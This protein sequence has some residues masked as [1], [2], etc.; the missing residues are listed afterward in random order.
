[1]KDREKKY[2]EYIDGKIDKY[3]RDS[4]SDPKTLDLSKMPP[5]TVDSSGEV[6]DG[7]HRAFLAIKQQKPLKGYKIVNANNTHP[8]VAKILQIVGKEKVNESLWANINAKKKRGEKS[9]HKNSKAY[10][11]AKKAGIALKKSK[12][13]EIV[14]EVLYEK[15]VHD[16]VKPGILK[17]RLG[18]LSCSKVRTARGKLKD[19]GTH[20]AKALQR[21]LN[22]H[23]Q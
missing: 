5:I 7:N 22:Y 2:Q 17:Q 19:K 20:Y 8:N 23:C 6:M 13:K 11:K 3:F 18:K 16:P 21:Y 12:L 1:M 14:L 9:S 15:S 10:K 4:D